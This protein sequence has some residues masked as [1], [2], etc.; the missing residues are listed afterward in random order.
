MSRPH[1]FRR[2]R[3]ELPPD[4]LTVF[5]WAHGHVPIA[6]CLLGG[7]LGPGLD[8]GGLARL[9]RLVAAAALANAGLL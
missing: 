7:Y 5:Q 4:Y 1:G 6:F 2:G 9:H 3:R 8:R